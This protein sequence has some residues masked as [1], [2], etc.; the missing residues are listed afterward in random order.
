MASPV[1][2]LGRTLGHYRILEQIGAGG[3]GVVYRAHD[4]RLERDVALKV[5]PS[6]TLADDSAR[7]R[8]RKEA[9]ALSRLNHPNI[10][11]VHDFDTQ[12]G[13]DFLV[14]ELVPGLTL[15][16]R[17]AAGPLPEKEV[18]HI[19]AQ[20]ADGLDAAHREGVIHRDLKP[21]N[22][23]L[24]PEGRLKILDFGLAKR[25]GP[26]DEGTI[27][28]SLSE[29]GG[30]AG[31]LAYMAPEALKGDKVDTR[32]DIWAAGV[33]LYE[34]ATG[35]RPFDGKTSTALADETLH[36][37]APSP[38][39][40]QPRLSSRLT[41]IILKC[42]EKDAENRYQSAKELLVDL[43]RLTLPTM[44]ATAATKR[45]RPQR[46][47]AWQTAAVAVVVLAAA[48]GMF[49]IYSSRAKAL[50]EGGT[51]VLADFVNTTGE[52]VFDGTL[53]QGLAAQLAQSPYIDLLP[54][55]RIQQTLKLMNRPPED[56]LVGPVARE[57]CQRQ[58]VKALLTGEIAALGSHY[59]ITLDALNC[60]TGAV[61]ARE[62]AEATS[63]EEV[64]ST[65]GKSATQLRRKLGESLA[66]IQK[67]D[68]PLEEATTSSLAALKQFSL[69]NDMKFLGRNSEAIPYYQR[70]IELDPNFALAHRLLGVVYG[71][72]GESDKSRECLTKAFKLRNRVSERERLA[73]DG[74]YYGAV[75]RELEK[76]R[77]NFE[78]HIRSYPRD[79]VPLTNLSGLLNNMG[80]F[81]N[82]V[83]LSRES[84]NLRPNVA[85]PHF[86]LGHAYMALNRIDEA[87]AAMEQQIARRVDNMATHRRLYV[88]GVLQG[89]TAA[90]QRQLEWAKDRPDEFD[91]FLTQADAAA[92]FGKRKKALELRRRAVERARQR[93]SIESASSTLAKT[94]LDEAR[95]NNC[96]QARQLIEASLL[97]Q[98]T[99][100]EGEGDAPSVFAL[101]G[102]VPRALALADELVKRFPQATMLNNVTIPEIRA[103]VETNRGNPAKAIELLRSA[104][105]FEKGNFSPTFTRG[106]AYLKAKSG[107]EAAAEFEKVLDRSGVSPLS[108]QT[109]LCRLELAR[110]WALA[111]EAEKARKSYQDFLA[112]WKDADPDIPVL[113]DAQSEYARLK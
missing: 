113:R 74:Y 57:V 61:M 3:M 35:R 88:I 17:I 81:E 101:C 50:T 1:L 32:A 26:A 110:A 108:V 75:T 95:Y 84:L 21:G 76:A 40:L 24:T 96:P 82:A 9:L 23:R 91:M 11:T 89:D 66:S 65:L 47:M 109:A 78:V 15:D 71:I 29:P 7:K 38:Q 60:V 111:G 79:P 93:G 72:T 19:G 20:M 80:D 12:E 41:D 90:M 64:L 43:R 94:A 103:I 77:E 45:E 8:F 92:Y 13:I 106:E 100:A 27:T 33:V 58:N 99:R 70:A 62:Q 46:R 97:L 56:R 53:K 36:A 69:G 30:A 87:K 107:K 102:D 54:D 16:E 22:L 55:D 67:L 83:K 34:M 98:R 14:T 105:P 73:I 63:K 44:P 68:K 85:V 51:I 25:V 4:E 112:L 86:H 5:L 104:E 28:Q 2:V 39:G 42:L 10:A 48:V 37:P 18:I 59:V 31:T 6:G 52:A 49:L